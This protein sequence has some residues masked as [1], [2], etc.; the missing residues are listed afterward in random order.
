MI[1]AVD[2]DG[3]LCEDKWPEIGEPNERLLCFCKARK[4]FGDKLIL[5][6]NRQGEKLAEA[7]DWCS[8]HGLVF[9]AVNEDLPETIERFGSSSRKIFAD[10][11]IDDRMLGGFGV[12]YHSAALDEIQ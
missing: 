8:K 10:F 5:W 11:F 12:P 1:F 4:R 3:T 6:T 9:D 7:I 2:F